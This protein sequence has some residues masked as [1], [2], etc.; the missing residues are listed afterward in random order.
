L[1]PGLKKALEDKDTE[2]EQWVC[3]EE[4]CLRDEVAHKAAEEQRIV[5][6]EAIASLLEDNNA[7][8]PEAFDLKLREIELQYG[9]GAM[10]DQMEDM[11]VVSQDHNMV[12]SGEVGG[13]QGEGEKGWPKPRPLTK[14]RAIAINSVGS[15]EDEDDESM[16]SEVAEL[17]PAPQ[18]LDRSH[19]E[20][21]SI[22]G[23]LGKLK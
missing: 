14:V 13:L 23:H 5:G 11:M 4:E 22:R 9:L 3:L 10:E 20:G 7:L 1:L 17:H 21:Q 16:K 8:S 15:D 12:E 2:C 19:L 18:K 6:E